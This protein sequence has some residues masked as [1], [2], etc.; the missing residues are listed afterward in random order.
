[1][2][3]ELR[4]LYVHAPVAD[5]DLATTYLF[6]HDDMGPFSGN[7][8]DSFL[9]SALRTFLSEER[10]R[11]FSPHSFRIYLACALRAAGCE[12]TVIQAM[13]RWQSIKSLHTYALLDAKS[14][15]E[16]ISRAMESDS[17]AVRVHDLPVLDAIDVGPAAD[18]LAALSDSDIVDDSAY[19]VDGP[20]C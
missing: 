6:V 4:D 14:Y 9:R 8:I 15:S 5:E 18:D 19:A 17:T 3:R 11:R 7:F 12:D 13:C 1:M 10:V 20:Y 2:A 16:F